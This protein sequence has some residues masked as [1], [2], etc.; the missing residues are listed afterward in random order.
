MF[1]ISSFLGKSAYFRP[2]FTV[3]KIIQG[4]PKFELNSI[5]LEM[6][7]PSIVAGSSSVNF[8]GFGFLILTSIYY[9]F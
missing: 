5:G 7:Q 1:V 2:K 6:G 8:I 4:K 9:Q 3:N